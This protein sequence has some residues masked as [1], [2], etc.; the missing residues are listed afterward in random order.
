MPNEKNVDDTLDYCIKTL[1]DVK[2]QWSSSIKKLMYVLQENYLKNDIE[3]SSD[4]IVGELISTQGK[5][6]DNRNKN[7]EFYNNKT[8]Q[9][10]FISELIE[11]AIKNNKLRKLG[12]IID[13]YRNN[14]NDNSWI[15]KV[16]DKIKQKKTEGK[17]KIENIEILEF[18]KD[19]H[20]KKK[21]KQLKLIGG[22]KDYEPLMKELIM[23]IFDSLVWFY[24]EDNRDYKQKRRI[25]YA[26]IKG[27]KIQET[28]FL[29]KSNSSDFLDNAEGSRNE[30]KKLKNKSLK[31]IMDVLEKFNE[32]SSSPSKL[33]S[34]G[35]KSKSD[36]SVRDTTDKLMKCIGEI[37][38]KIKKVS[39]DLNNIT[40]DSASA[41]S[42]PPADGSIPSLVTPKSTVQ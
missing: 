32:P 9:N 34:I 5:Y 42:A 18:I 38:E 40:G 1:Q 2:K 37:N 26:G 21:V 25:S 14:S 4:T 27:K 36:T 16:E 22:A 30:I 7:Q 33:S 17:E 13:R 35:I 41:P 20:K 24:K 19:E 8:V 29:G 11:W 23:A 28:F 10:A 15:S 39:E 3:A 31:D 12:K 6:A